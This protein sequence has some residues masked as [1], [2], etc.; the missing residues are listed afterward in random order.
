MVSKCIARRPP[1]Q[2]AG[3]QRRDPPRAFSRFVQ[4]FSQET[5]Y[6]KGSKNLK[7]TWGGIKKNMPK[8]K[9]REV[10]W[11]CLNEEGCPNSKLAPQGGQEK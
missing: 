3:V 8:R 4:G 5:T 10:G 9:K 1:N 11:G 2:V 6:P 7:V